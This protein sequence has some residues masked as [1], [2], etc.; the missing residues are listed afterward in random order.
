[1]SSVFADPDADEWI[2]EGG[3][4]A[5]GPG[6]SSF[7]VRFSGSSNDG[8][9]KNMATLGLEHE[10]QALS[11][12]ADPLAAAVSAQP[13]HHHRDWDSLTWDSLA[14]ADQARVRRVADLFHASGYVHGRRHHLV[15]YRAC[16]VAREFVEWAVASGHAQDRERATLLG[17]Q[18][19]TGNIVHHVVDQHAFSDSYL[20]F[21]YRTDD[22][23]T[24]AELGDE[25]DEPERAGSGPVEVEPSTYMIVKVALVAEFGKDIDTLFTRN[26]HP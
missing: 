6:S 18:M 11:A 21:R 8:P 14:P 19:A 2:R 7:A 15:R 26:T 16:F 1:M 4:K 13:K 10:Q 20:F 5:D 3:A 24:A 25:L 22:N 23:A 17:A 12:A 9:S